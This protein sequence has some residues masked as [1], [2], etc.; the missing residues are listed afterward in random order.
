MNSIYEKD[1]HDT[2]IIV[3]VGCNT[4]NIV[5]IRSR[6]TGLW[7]FPGDRIRAEDIDPDQPHNHDQAARNAISRATKQRTGLTIEKMKCIVE[8]QRPLGMFYGYVGLADFGAFAPSES[9]KD[10]VVVVSH[11]GLP[12]SLMPVIQ[13]MAFESIV[14]WIRG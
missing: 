7:R 8:A 1:P 14:R 6:R 9:D 12:L 13:G 11:A 10:I 5:L 3:L 4:S 2:A